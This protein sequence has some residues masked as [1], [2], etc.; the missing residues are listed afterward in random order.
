MCCTAATSRRSP[1]RYRLH[2]DL[3]DLAERLTPLRQDD[4]PVPD[5]PPQHAR[6]ARWVRPE[7]VGE[8][9]FTEWTRR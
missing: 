4:P 1:C 2:R 8:V 9:A 3:D 6:D 7:R 5:V